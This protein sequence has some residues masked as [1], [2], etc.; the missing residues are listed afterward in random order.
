MKDMGQFYKKLWILVLPIALQNLLSAIVSASDALMLGMLDQQSLSAISLA[1]QV[2][3]VLSLFFAALTIGTTILAAQYW[4]K[5]NKE[6]V[7][8][9]LAIALRLS[10]LISVVFFIAALFF[11]GL[12]MRIFTNDTELIKLGIP[13][14]RIV[15][16]SYLCMGISQIYLCI[17][18]NSG[19][20]FRSTIY[21]STTVV[22]N[23]ILNTVLIFGLFG[24]PKLEISGA[25]I[26]TVIARIVE[27][28]LVL[29]ENQKQDVVRIRINY[30]MH[31]EKELWKDF[32]HY[33]TPV[34]ANELVWGC[35]FTMFSV[36]MG[37]LGSDAVAANSIANIVKN[38][39][40][41]VCLG[42]GTGSGILIG[43][44]LG[45][46]DLEKARLYGDKLCHVAIFVG[47]VSNLII[48]VGIP[49][50]LR[51]AGN[52][53]DQAYSYLRF[54]LFICGYYMIGK[55]I[56]STVISGIFCAGG[57]TKFGFLCD[58]VTMWVVIVPLGAIAAFVLKLPVLMVYF[59]LNLDELIKLPAVYYHYKKYNRVKNLTK[60]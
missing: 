12:L 50:I 19:R 4:G 48:L 39:I 35:G 44:E 3:F 22:I 20:T 24:M 9:V 16:V 57:D 58:T 5:D 28:L 25:A 40:A 56:N 26:A 49:I 33:T 15:S 59:L 60:E 2:Q 47:V 43:N 51:C 18:K 14:L 55:S 1:T 30:L 52:L 38:I 7:E 8:K 54:M 41:C 10:F 21:G 17:M 46:G 36:I 32:L 42:I 34:L 45:R 13:Y 11:P 31:R 37:H 27:L 23:L 53:T 6:A 29:L